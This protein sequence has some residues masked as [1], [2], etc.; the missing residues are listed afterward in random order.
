MIVVV[1]VVVIVTMI[2]VVVVSVLASAPLT[3]SRGKFTAAN[4]PSTAATAV[5][6]N[7][8]PSLARAPP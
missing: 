1:I 8:P 2:V 3:T 4:P 6:S 5:P 7:T